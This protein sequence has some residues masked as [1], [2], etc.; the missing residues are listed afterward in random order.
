M[1]TKD[2][3]CFVIT[4]CLCVGLDGTLVGKSNPN[5]GRCN[6][7]FTRVDKIEKQKDTNGGSKL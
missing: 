2:S 7:I 5:A 1:D 6:R 3:R 4:G